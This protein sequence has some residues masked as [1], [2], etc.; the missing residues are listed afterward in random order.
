MQ[1]DWLRS[2]KGRMKG[3]RKGAVVEIEGL[4]IEPTKWKK[5]EAIIGH[6][7]NIAE[8][9]AEWKELK[10]R[11]H[12]GPFNEMDCWNLV[13]YGFTNDVVLNRFI[14]T[15]LAR[16]W[17]KDD[18]MEYIFAIDPVIMQQCISRKDLSI[19]MESCQRYKNLLD[20]NDDFP[21]WRPY[22]NDGNTVFATINYPDRVHWVSI[23]VHLS[24]FKI[25]E[26]SEL[27]ECYKMRIFNPIQERSVSDDKKI[28]QSMTAFMHSVGL[29]LKKIPVVD[30]TGIY[31]IFASL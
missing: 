30:I 8:G 1:A 28:A 10:N 23:Q 29:D 6:Y 19:D 26:D 3:T 15:I 16:L 5:V 2:P 18:D 20:H 31:N 9:S 4:L 25:A 14:Q 12:A 7:E 21:D 17:H 13:N 27:K 22:L 24:K 11:H